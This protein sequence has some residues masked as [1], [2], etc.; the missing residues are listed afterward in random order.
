MTVLMLL[1]RVIVPTMVIFLLLGGVASA[2]M[3][4]ALVFRTEKA[5]AFMRS[6]NR[7]VSTRR[8]LKQAEIPRTVGTAS[9][10]GRVLLALFLLFGGVFALYVL[11]LR[12]EIPRAALILG[13]NLRRWFIT[14]IA[15]QTLKWFLVVGSVL[16]LV[17]AA[18]ILF[19]P[20]RLAALEGRLNKWYSTRHILPPAGDSMRL[21]LEVIVEGSPHAAGWVIAVA[22]LI[23]AAAM[24]VLLAA[25][26][27]G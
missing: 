2:A 6:M 25:R 27:A 16:A 12:I 15:L 9:R 23:V 8:A 20:G 21:P 11:L 18:L 10:K 19:F 13:V 3:G 24:A 17:V 5:L 4:F 22:S 14:G 26:I 1:E 7:W